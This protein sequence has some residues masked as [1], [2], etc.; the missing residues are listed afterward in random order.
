MIRHAA[1]PR[2]NT[3]EQALRLSHHYNGKPNEITLGLY[4]LYDRFNF[5]MILPIRLSPSFLYWYEALVNPSRDR[6]EPGKKE[7]MFNT[8]F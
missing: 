4:G 1:W 6:R 5:I 3:A 2:P 7:T 8:C